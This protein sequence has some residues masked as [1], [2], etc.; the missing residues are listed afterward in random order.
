MFGIGYQEM[1][2]ILVVA[3]V[4]FGP[5]R[6]PEPVVGIGRLLGRDQRGQGDGGRDEREPGADRAPG[7]SRAPTRGLE[8]NPG[9]EAWA[10]QVG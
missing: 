4:V 9:D 10:V 5:A 2:V 7:V 8:R 6:L 3:L 1:F